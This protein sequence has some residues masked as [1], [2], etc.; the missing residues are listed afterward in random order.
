MIQKPQTRVFWPKEASSQLL[1]F[2]YNTQSELKMPQVITSIKTMI[3][4]KKGNQER[5][6]KHNW[7]KTRIFKMSWQKSC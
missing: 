4:Q 6:A 1:P 3:Y 5:D 7:L 2:K